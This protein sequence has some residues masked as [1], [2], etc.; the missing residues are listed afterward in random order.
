MREPVL[1]PFGVRPAEC[2][3]EGLAQPPQPPPA[4]LGRDAQQPRLAGK[5]EVL[6]GDTAHLAHVEQAEGG[7]ALGEVSLTYFALQSV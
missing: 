6:D 1:H 7:A 3:S 5:L 4:Q 2:L